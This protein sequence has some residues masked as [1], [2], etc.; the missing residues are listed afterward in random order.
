MRVTLYSRAADDHVLVWT[1]HH[2]ICDAWSMWMLMLEL[3]E[4]YPATLVGRRLPLTPLNHQFHNFV[5]WQNEMLDGER[6][7]LLWQYWSEKLSGE[8]PVLN[9]PTD[10]PHPLAQSLRGASHFFKLDE[11]LARPCRVE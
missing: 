6:G 9:L 8:L 1:F 5:A 10:R 4:V 11:P 7:Q 2:I 3:S